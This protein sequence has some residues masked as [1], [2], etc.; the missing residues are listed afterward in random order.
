VLSPE[1]KL[2]AHNPNKAKKIK[3]IFFFKNKNYNK[4]ETILV[5]KQWSEK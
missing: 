3:C 1:F 4:G 5:N 2:Q